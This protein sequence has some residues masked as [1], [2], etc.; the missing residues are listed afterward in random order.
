[1]SAKTVI[2]GLCA[3]LI[4]AIGAYVW[5]QPQAGPSQPPIAHAAPTGA[6][7]PESGPEP[8]TATTTAKVG[9]TTEAAPEE[10]APP[11]G[12]TKAE[13]ERERRRLELERAAGKRFQQAVR[14]DGL[15]PSDV[16]P[17][18]R[19]MFSTVTLQPV[20]D[21]ETGTPGYVE[22]MRIAEIAGNNPLARAG[23]GRGDRITRINGDPLTDPAQIAHLFTSL[24]QRFEV[25]AEQE[26]GRRCRIVTL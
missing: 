22:G 5:L 8:D 6:V 24:G 7:A 17:S 2:A 4:A 11:E 12:M 18:V 13:A 26:G 25:C 9:K 15:K 23:F 14:M 16:A 3:A 19:A 20:V 1:M 10:T 21:P